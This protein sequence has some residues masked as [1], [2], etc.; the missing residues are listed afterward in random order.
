[1]NSLIYIEVIKQIN[2]SYQKEF[3]SEL[4]ETLPNLDVFDLDNHSEASLFSYAAELIRK[5]DKCVLL[6]KVEPNATLGKAM[7][8]VEEVL[9]NKD[10]CYV[11][12]QGQNN[13]MEKITR[14]LTKVEWLHDLSSCYALVNDYLKPGSNSK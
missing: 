10:K 6:F 2:F 5:S 1:M 8:V 13:M 4:K 7:M 11:I 3:I 12:V 9:K 14:P